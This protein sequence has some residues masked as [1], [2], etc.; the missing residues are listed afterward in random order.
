[1][2]RSENKEPTRPED[3]LKLFGDPFEPTGRERA[4]IVMRALLGFEF[5]AG[6]FVSQPQ[7]PF[8]PRGLIIWGAPNGATVE[9]C[10]IGTQLQIQVSV[11]PV[12][13]KFFAM[14]K[15]YEDVAKMLEQGIEPP[16]WCT[17]DAVQLGQ[18]VRL[19]VRDAHHG[20]L[21]PNNGIELVMW[22]HALTR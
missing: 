10:I 15:S 1:M 8:R 6:E 4:P 9:Q 14:G 2:D 22:G 21:G 13:A 5:I 18:I 16:G 20:T 12:P 3:P 17:W 7:R 11:P 19:T